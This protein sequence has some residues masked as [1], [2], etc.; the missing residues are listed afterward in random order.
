M[1]KD[2]EIEIVRMWHFKTKPFFI[3]IKIEGHSS[4]GTLSVLIHTLLRKAQEITSLVGSD[5]NRIFSDECSFFKINNNN[6]SKNLGYKRKS[7]FSRISFF[8]HSQK[9]IS[10]CN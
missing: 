2:M 8:S 3:P 4:L 9:K 10:H 7:L 5:K 6:Y 1:V